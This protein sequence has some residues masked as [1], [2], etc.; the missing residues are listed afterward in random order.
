LEELVL[1]RGVFG[2]DIARIGLVVIFEN[3]VGKASEHNIFSI[4]L[5]KGVIL[6]DKINLDR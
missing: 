4:C 6:H 2:P 3:A 5:V 1:P